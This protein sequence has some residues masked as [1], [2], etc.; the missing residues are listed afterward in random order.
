MWRY[1]STLKKTTVKIIDKYIWGILFLFVY[2]GTITASFA[3]LT[4]I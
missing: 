1:I 2:F 3:L 4:L